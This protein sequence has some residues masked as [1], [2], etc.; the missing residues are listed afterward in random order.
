M[1]CRE[2]DGCSLGDDTTAQMFEC[3]GAELTLATA[4]LAIVI[5]A[6]P[7]WLT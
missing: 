3:F 4:T 2:Y 1:N 5:T 7:P 6:T